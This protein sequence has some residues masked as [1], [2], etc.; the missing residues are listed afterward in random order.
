MKYKLGTSI[1]GSG[2]RKSLG[3]GAHH[4]SAVASLSLCF[5]DQTASSSQLRL[6]MSSAKGLLEGETFSIPLKQVR[7]LWVGTWRSNGSS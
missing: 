7:G 3:A 2:V 6:V 4:H 5:E 1:G